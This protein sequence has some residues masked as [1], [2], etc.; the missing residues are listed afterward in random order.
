MKTPQTKIQFSAEVKNWPYDKFIKKF[1]NV[2]DKQV[3]NKYA[4]EFGMMPAPVGAV[5]A[6]TS[7]TEVVQIPDVQQDA[8]KKK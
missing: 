7:D 3:L 2:Y 5:K 8:K 1:E 6:E 4:I